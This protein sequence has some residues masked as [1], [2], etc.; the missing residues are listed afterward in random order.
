MDEPAANVPAVL[1][2]QRMGDLIARRGFMRVTELSTEFGVSGVTVRGDL[3][4]L[5]R[6]RSVVRVHGGA[7][8]RSAVAHREFSF[9]ESLES[10]ARAKERIGAAA[11]ELVRSGQS[12]LLDVGTTTLAVARALVARGDLRDV[13]IVTNGLTIALELEAAIPRFT[14]VVTGG[15]LRPLQHSLVNPLAAVLLD[16]VH[17]DVAFIG[18]NGVDADRG[19]TNINLPEA[20]VKRRMLGSATRRIVVADATKLGRVHLGAIGAL[21]AFDCVV[22]D[23][24]ADGPGLRALS[25]AGIELIVTD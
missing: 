22:T 12:V 20:E 7:V 23:A 15:T 4:D 5:V 6:S 9:E 2:R 17:V 11:A 25:D 16:Q 21:S 13:V 19:V 3:D 1:R 8:P 14:V 18:C 10:S 24:R